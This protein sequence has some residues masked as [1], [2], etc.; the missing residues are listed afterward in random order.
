MCTFDCS[1]G[2][3]SKVLT[4]SGRSQPAHSQSIMFIQE[5]LCHFLDVKRK[6]ARD[7]EYTE[8]APEDKPLN[9]VE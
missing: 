2:V 4:L 5:N 6:R 7:D 9:K 1:S 3:F 8:Y